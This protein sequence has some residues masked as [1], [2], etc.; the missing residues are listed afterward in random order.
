MPTAL[1]NSSNDNDIVDKRAGRVIAWLIITIL[2][3]PLPIVIIGLIKFLSNFLD[4]GKTDRNTM[5]LLTIVLNLAIPGIISVGFLRSINI[6][7]SRN[8]RRTLLIQSFISIGILIIILPLL[9][10]LSYGIARP[11]GPD[12]D[13]GASLIGMAVASLT[14]PVIAMS[15]SI[16]V[17]LFFT[18]FNNS[19][20]SPAFHAA[21]VILPAWLIQ[22]IFIIYVRLG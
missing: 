14:A 4:G 12:Y 6:K 9:I 1:N 21:T 19:R 17:Y 5:L 3:L 11:R 2:L 20:L 13:Y 16:I 22:Y 8:E 7:V 18:L 10:Y 15:L